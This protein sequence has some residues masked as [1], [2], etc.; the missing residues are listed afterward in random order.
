MHCCHCAH[1]LRDHRHRRPH[2]TAKRASGSCQSSSAT[3]AATQH[4]GA[5]A[6]QQLLVSAQGVGPTLVSQCHAQPDT[7]CAA[8]RACNVT[9]THEPRTMSR[10]SSSSSHA[11]CLRELWQ[12]SQPPGKHCMPSIFCNIPIASTIQ[13]VSALVWRRVAKTQAV[14]SRP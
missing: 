1:M 2:R 6:F 11:T 3:S 12:P 5:S 4:H 8:A 13:P 14:S 9:C 10:L 7:F